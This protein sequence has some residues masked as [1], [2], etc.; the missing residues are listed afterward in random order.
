MDT[1]SLSHVEI[2][3]ADKGE[4]AAVFATFNVVDLDGDV[5]RPDAFTDG[6]D[7]VISAYGHRSWEGVLPVGSGIIKTTPTEAI[8]YGQFFMDTTAGRET[9]SVVKALGARQAWSYGFE[10]LES[11][12]GEFEGKSVRFLRKVQPYEVS[13]TLRGAGIGTRVVTAKSAPHT[14]GAHKMINP[15]DTSV[16]SRA[17]NGYDTTTAIPDGV[18]PSDLRSV[19]AWVDPTGDPELKS[20]YKFPHHHGVDGSANARA[21]LAGIATLNSTK[22]GIG[23]Q[24]Q[25]AVHAHLAGHL[26]DFDREPPGLR[27]DGDTPLK[28]NDEL[29]EGLAGLSVLVDKASRVVALRAE[30]GKTLSRVNT[31]VL[32]WITD[33][34]KRLDALL[35]NPPAGVVSEEE[36]TSTLLASLARIHGL[37]RAEQSNVNS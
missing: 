2:K 9:F 37:G 18:R 29:A 26:R 31:E 28:F 1:K 7:V 22:S 16:V 32:E 15:H 14:V 11:E 13:P 6:S 12:P 25:A 5:T 20:S 19:Y 34:L 23:E 4:V 33:D 17:W 36:L 27:C 35:T 21:C 3:N 30:K 10:I 8:L 24:D